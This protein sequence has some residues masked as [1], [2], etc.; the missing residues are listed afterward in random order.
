LRQDVWDEDVKEEEKA[1]KSVK[2]VLLSKLGFNTEGSNSGDLQFSIQSGLST[3]Y[4]RSLAN[5]RGS[6]ATPCWMEDQIH[7]LIKGVPEI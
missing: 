6:E 2:P 1:E 5:T 7:K 4:A 3:I